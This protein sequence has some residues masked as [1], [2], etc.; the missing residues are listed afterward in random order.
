MGSLI[1]LNPG[2]LQHGINSEE[3]FSA[4]W[5]IYFL[6]IQLLYLPEQCLP[7]CPA[8]EKWLLAP[9]ALLQR[10]VVLV[11]RTLSRSL[12]Q[13]SS[14]RKYLIDLVLSL[15]CRHRSLNSGLD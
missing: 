6:L 3:H 7:K 9:L 5:E 12:T 11:L 1:S 8:T 10:L 2:L 14:E 4:E 13:L 15:Q